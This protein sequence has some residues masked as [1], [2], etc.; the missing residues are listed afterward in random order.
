V[1]HCKHGGGAAHSDH[2]LQIN[3]SRDLRS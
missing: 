1:V 3:L 2:A